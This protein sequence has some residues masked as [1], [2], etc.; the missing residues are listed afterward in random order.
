M[1][2]FKKNIKGFKLKSRIFNKFDVLLPSRKKDILGTF[3]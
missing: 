3:A 2:H 1:V